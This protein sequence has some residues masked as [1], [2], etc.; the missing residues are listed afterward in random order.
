MPCL[1]ADALI[2]DPEGMAFLRDVLAQPAADAAFPVS[3][4]APPVPTRRRARRLQREL[5]ERSLSVAPVSVPA[6]AAA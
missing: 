5:P 3:A 2:T 1:T 6:D 4:N